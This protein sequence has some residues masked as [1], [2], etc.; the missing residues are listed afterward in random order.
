MLKISLLLRNLQT[1][2]ANNSRIPGIKNG[3]LLGYCFYMNTNIKGDFRICI[4][5]PLIQVHV[6]ENKSEIKTFYV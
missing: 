3:K 6:E 5:V 1:S 2:R 4:S